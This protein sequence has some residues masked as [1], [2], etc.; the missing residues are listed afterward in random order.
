M[1]VCTT[2]VH[3]A[4]KT[5]FSVAL[6]TTQSS[7]TEV[8]WRMRPCLVCGGGSA[9]GGSVAVVEEVAGLE[10]LGGVFIPFVL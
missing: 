5:V 4:T 3:E 2:A 6:R 8:V 7:T 9:E 10:F 1:C